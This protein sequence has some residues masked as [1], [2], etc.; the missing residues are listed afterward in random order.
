MSGEF[1][2][3]SVHF[4]ELV[5]IPQTLDAWREQ[6]D[7]R[8]SDWLPKE[9]APPTELH[10]AMRYACLAPGKRLRPLLCLASAEAVG[11]TPEAAL[12]GGCAIEMVHAFSLVHDDLPC[13]DDDD[14]RRGKPTCHVKFGEAIAVL[15]GDAL[16]ALAFEVISKASS[17]SE[18]CAQATRLL[19]SASGSSGLVGGEVLD[20]LSEGR[21]VSG[22]VVDEI[23]RKKTAALIAASCR[24][25]ALLGG[26]TGQQCLALEHFGFEI[27]LAFQ[28]ADDIL[29]ETSTAEELG[30]AAGSDRDR[31][32]ATYPSVHGLKSSSEAAKGAVERSLAA[33]VEVGLASPMLTHLA[34]STVERSS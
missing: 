22:A 19:A 23:H 14:L 12:D 10:Q 29:N 1:T 33:L 13:I 9:S 7:A 34:T 15:A 24:I 4:V 21:E 3:A 2:N 18:A 6:I 11:A 25:G 8:L 26:G 20:V 5:D 32:K 27:G 16:F 30:K 17:Q 28:I 31:K